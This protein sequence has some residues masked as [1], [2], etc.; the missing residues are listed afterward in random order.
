MCLKGFRVL[1]QFDCGRHQLIGFAAK[2]FGGG[3]TRHAIIMPHEGCHRESLFCVVIVRRGAL[4]SAYALEVALSVHDMAVLV[5]G[6]V[7][8]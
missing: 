3:F 1:N 7:G 8:I 2:P 5:S 4:V 6:L